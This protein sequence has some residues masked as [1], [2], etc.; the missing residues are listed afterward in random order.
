MSGRGEAQ[1]D[2]LVVC[3]LLILRISLRVSIVGEAC[4]AAVKLPDGTIGSTLPV[5]A[6][7]DQN[8]SDP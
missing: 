5:E 6:P 8:R 4:L 7:D 2:C 1:S 3:P